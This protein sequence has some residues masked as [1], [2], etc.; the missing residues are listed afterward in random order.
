MNL[1]YAVS[2]MKGLRDTMEDQHIHKIGIPVEGRGE[3]EDHA[4]F[5][6][7]DGH[8]GDFTSKYL[9]SNFIEAF[10]K[11]Q[12]LVKYSGLQK[13][14]SR[15]R[16]D[17]NAVVLLQKALVKTFVQLDEQLHPLHKERTAAIQSGR[18]K[19]SPLITEEVDDDV[20]GDCCD[21]GS[22]NNSTNNATSR[23]AKL[24]ERSGSTAVV[25]VLTPTHIICAN[26]GD[27]RAV[28]RRKGQTLPM[29]FDHKPTELPERLR[30]TG[31]GGFVKGRRVNGDLAVSRAFG[32]FLYKKGASLSS[33]EQKV[34]VLPDV[35]V[36]PR[37]DKDD[38]FMILAC[39][40]I[41]DVASNTQC[42]NFVQVLLSEGENDLGNICE[43]ILDTCLDR[44]SRDNMT[45]ML[46]GLPAMKQDTSSSAV[47]DNALWG[48]K[49]SRQTHSGIFCP[50]PPVT[51]L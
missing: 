35:M 50:G 47:I 45:I 42:T 36:Y 24:G 46:V 22:P 11:R 34:I 16:S 37:Y 7:F 8:G 32:D 17:V 44:Q 10:S 38:E 29:S 33:T 40:G 9:A 20:D 15:G 14:G 30:I 27:S 39:D 51:V 48:Y 12:E 43:E 28:L 13:S 5:G 23:S 31:T 21:G 49:A 18:L 2:G 3:L 25:V 41:W 4:I 6:V 26:T 1:R 19:P